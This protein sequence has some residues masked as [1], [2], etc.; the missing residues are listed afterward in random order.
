MFMLLGARAHRSKVEKADLGPM[1]R[2][3]SNALVRPTTRGPGPNPAV[4]DRAESLLQLR[5]R[6]RGTPPT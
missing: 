5:G 2:R 1:R 4:E 3:S 6:S